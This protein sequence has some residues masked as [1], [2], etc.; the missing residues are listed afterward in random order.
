MSAFEL[1]IFLRKHRID[2]LTK[3]LILHDY[4]QNDADL[5]SQSPNPIYDAK[6]GLRTNTRELRYKDRYNKE[7][8]RLISEVVTMDASYIPPPDYKPPKKNR[9]IY[10]PMDSDVNYIG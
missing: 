9:K 2:D 1:E 10:V 7:R 3:R 6:T 4:E 5:R 8:Y